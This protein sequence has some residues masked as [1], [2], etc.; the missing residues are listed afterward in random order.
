M[1]APKL[2]IFLFLRPAVGL[3]PPS[4]LALKASTCSKYSSQYRHLPLKNQLWCFMQWCTVIERHRN[5]QYEKA[6]LGTIP[7]FACEKFPGSEPILAT[8]MKSVVSFSFASS[9]ATP[10]TLPFGSFSI[11]TS[12]FGTSAPLFSSTPPS[13]LSNFSTPFATDGVSV[14]HGEKNV[15]KTSKSASKAGKS[16]EPEN[17]KPQMFWAPA[18]LTAKS[19]ADVDDDDY[20]ATIAPPQSPWG[21]G[22]EGSNK[23]E[24]THKP[25]ALEVVV[26][27]RISFKYLLY[28]FA[29]FSNDLCAMMDYEKNLRYLMRASLAVFPYNSSSYLQIYY[30]GDEWFSVV[31]SGL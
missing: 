19:W 14:P 6:I 12:A 27:M 2:T 21:E 1:Q 24:E 11:S 23:P 16:K 18:P 22:G 25:D 8:Q 9:G 13:R 20:Y 30:N 17:E 4:K 15:G 31:I 10:Q 3:H 26:D 7:Q 29:K 28:L 5:T